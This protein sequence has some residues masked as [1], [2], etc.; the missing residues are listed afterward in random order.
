MAKKKT[1]QAWIVLADSNKGRLMRCTKTPLDRCNVK[2][3]DHIEYTWEGH[4]H[5]R[6][7]P[8]TAKSGVN[9]AS[10]GHEAE[11]DTRRFA[12][13][14]A[15]WLEERVESHGIERLVMF[16]PPSFMGAFRK[17][18]PSRLTEMIE[19]EKGEL[20]G[21]DERALAKHPSIL[22]LMPGNHEI[23]AKGKTQ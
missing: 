9:Y 23:S 1:S 19:Q 16:S 6:P 5:G 3:L 8:R 2:E 11:E 22:R 7:S 15:E 12:R 18:C 4:E 17:L 13:R 10:Q 21:L 14:L 20:T